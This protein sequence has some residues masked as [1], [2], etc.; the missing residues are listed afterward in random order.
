MKKQE[1]ENSLMDYVLKNNATETDLEIH[2][3][4]SAS[5]PSIYFSSSNFVQSFLVTGELL[6]V[7]SNE[8]ISLPFPSFG[9]RQKIIA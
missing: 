5:N 3:H 6:F 2:G 9:L 8:T 4:T 1:C 7:F